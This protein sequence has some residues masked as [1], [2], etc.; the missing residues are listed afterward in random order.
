MLFIRQN[1]CE[2]TTILILQNLGTRYV[3]LN[4]HQD[5]LQASKVGGL[6]EP[7][8]FMCYDSSTSGQQELLGYVIATLRELSYFT[9]DPVF[10]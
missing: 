1:H 9:A 3:I 10:R 5:R 2:K 8:F 7:L 6:D 4:T